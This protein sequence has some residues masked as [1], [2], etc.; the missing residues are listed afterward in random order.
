MSSATVSLGA[1]PGPQAANAMR[2]ATPH[3]ASAGSSDASLILQGGEVDLRTAQLRSRAH[4]VVDDESARPSGRGQ[5][6][7][8]NTP[9][10]IQVKFPIPSVVVPPAV[11]LQ[12]GVR[13]PDMPV[14]VT[15]STLPLRSTI[16]V[17]R[18]YVW[19]FCQ[20]PSRG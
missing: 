2:L 18:A 10:L 12:L 14:A 5:S 15:I 16:R 17:C 8:G 11:V 19:K 13:G 6:G 1:L 4:D 9:A 7:P 20:V 3:R